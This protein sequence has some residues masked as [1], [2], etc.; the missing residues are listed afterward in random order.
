MRR[1]FRID[2]N[3]PE[4]VAALRKG[5]ASV[6]HTHMVGNGFPDLV[7]STRART[8]L[9]EIKDGS[10]PPSKRQLTED[11]KEFHAA[12]KGEIWLIES[13]DDVKAILEAMRR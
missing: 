4:I 9:V 12:W 6:A 3:Q 7:V 11:Q 10:L 5:G 13:I 8:V 2:A 1:T